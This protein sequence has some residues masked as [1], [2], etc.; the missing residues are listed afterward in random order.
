M[1]HRIVYARCDFYVPKDSS[2]AQL[3]KAK[4]NLQRMLAQIPLTDDERDAVEDGAATVERLI[5]RLADVP[6]PAGL[7]PRQLTQ[8]GAFIPPADLGVR[9][10]NG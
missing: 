7:T 2:R 1:P 6:T 9:T 3:L 10:T 8:S 4:D 5:A